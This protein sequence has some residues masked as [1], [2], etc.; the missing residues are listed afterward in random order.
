MALPDTALCHIPALAAWTY[1]SL[2]YYETLGGLGSEGQRKQLLL[3]RILPMLQR[4]TGRMWL[5][6]SDAKWRTGD[7]AAIERSKCVCKA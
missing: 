2:E 7:A 6:R 5:A 1:R 4:K 3:C